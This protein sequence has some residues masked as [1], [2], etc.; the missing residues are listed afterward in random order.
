MPSMAP[1][2]WLNITLAAGMTVWPLPRS[3][4]LFQGVSKI[5]ML[6][7][8][9]ALSCCAPQPNSQDYA[10]SILDRPLPADEASAAGECDFLNRE[11]ARQKAIEHAL[12]NNDLLPKTALAIEK[13][14][15]TNIAALELRAKRAACTS[16]GDATATTQDRLPSGQ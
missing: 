6:A 9:I 4:A 15:Q 14:T 12:P 1:G 13:A 2:N 7:I 3:K 11:I 10:R 16:L 8:A 5:L